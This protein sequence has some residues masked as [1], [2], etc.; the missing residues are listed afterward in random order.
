MTYQEFPK[1]PSP[2]D[3]YRPYQQGHGVFQDR[4]MDD[5]LDR[6]RW[7]STRLD[8]TNN[9]GGQRWTTVDNG[10]ERKSEWERVGLVLFF[11]SSALYIK[12]VHE[13]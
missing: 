9:N 12:N 10:G 6:T 5:L 11:I 8:A 13:W 1:N 7:Y 2:N 3:Q 4:N